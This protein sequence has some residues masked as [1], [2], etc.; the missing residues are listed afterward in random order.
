MKRIINGI[1]AI[2]IA[3]LLSCTEDPSKSE[4][5][6][7]VNIATPFEI[8]LPSYFPPMPMVL[9]NPMTVEGINLGRRLFYDPIL[10]GNNTQACA[11]CHQQQSAFVDTNNRFSKGIDGF[12]GFR[13]AMPLFNLAWATRYNWDGQFNSLEAQIPNPIFLAFEMHEDLAN[14]VK[15]LQMDKEYQELFA[16]AFGTN[17]INVDRISKSISQFMRTIIS[18]NPKIVPGIGEQIRTPQESRGFLVFLD[19]TKG[20]CFH[21]HEVNVFAS[22]FKF[23]NNGLNKNPLLDAGLYGQTG[24]LNDVG[25]FK[26]PSLLNLKYTAPYMH[27]GRFNS[28]EEVLDFYDKGFHDSPTLDPNLKKHLGA[29]SKPKPRSWTN[30]DKTD[31][32][33][34]LRALS[35]TTLLTNPAYSKP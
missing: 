10:S 3:Q 24:N 33:A 30:Q 22:N 17:D 11:N 32:L 35:D 29:D 18:H 15:E 14:A 12:E 28:L 7:K 8:K 16:L 27:D 1:I 23:V 6:V 5:P 2:I 25:K 31:L 19:E 9:S 13:N 26:T 21:C 4:S 34:F 20:D